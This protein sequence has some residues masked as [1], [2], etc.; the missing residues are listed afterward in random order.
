MLEGAGAPVVP[1]GWAGV[2]QSRVG[3]GVGV[4][5]SV[6]GA[7]MKATEKHLCLFWSTLG[8]R[9]VL[10]GWSLGVRCGCSL[11]V[12]WGLHRVISLSSFFLGGGWFGGI[13]NKKL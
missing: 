5:L 8:G 13:T 4:I 2:Q 6:L 9:V 12:Y 11:M 3:L 7:K 10:F 1:G